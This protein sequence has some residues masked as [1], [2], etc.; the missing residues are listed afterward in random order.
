MKLSQQRILG[1]LLALLLSWVPL[2]ASAQ[3]FSLQLQWVPQAQFAGYY[4]AYD[5]GWYADAGLNVRILPHG[6]E[7]SPTRLMA[8]G[9]VDI[10][11]F[12]LGEALQLVDSGIAI[13]N[14]HQFK[15]TSSLVLVAMA[16][17]G[18]LVPEDLDGLRV[19]RWTSFAAQPDALFSLYGIRP[20]VFD[21]GASMAILTSGAV[22]VAMATRYNEMVQL[23]LNGLEREDLIVLP[24]A[25]HGVNMPEDGIYVR[26]REWEEREDALRKFVEISRR[27]WQYA[28][29]NPDYAVETVIW[30]AQ[31]A[32]HETNEA[33]QRLMLS[34]LRDFYLDESG[35]LH[36]GQLNPNDYRLAWELLRG[37]GMVRGEQIP[38]FNHFNRR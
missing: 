21:Q 15:Q 1:C 36:E 11:V 30:R 31:E 25:N 38:D 18:I 29:E 22:D 19:S 9:Y 32:G 12:N 33:H 24:L 2:G 6:P 26:L 20:Q 28:F 4:V 7:F 17:A 10:G 13:V 23:Y 5:K 27:G 37:Q 34:V 16:D 8:D 14:I 35:R 3:T